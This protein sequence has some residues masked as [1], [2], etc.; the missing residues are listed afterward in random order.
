[1]SVTIRVILA[2]LAGAI[3]LLLRRTSQA[4]REVREAESRIARRFYLL[5]GRV[6]EIDALVREL[7]FERRRLRR[8][9]RFEPSTRLG[10]AMAVHPRVREILGGF[11]ISGSGCSGGAL[12]ESQTIA[13]A[14][15]A[16]S[17]DT[18]AVLAAL[19]R[20]LDD[21][22]APVDASASTARIYRIQTRPGASP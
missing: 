2:V 12:D 6:T 9:I 1:M 3:L 5:Q 14:C 16:S 15:A 19:G 10:E 21:P 17:L 4:R 22:Q 18:R 8:E 20:F 11:G 13:E 7:D